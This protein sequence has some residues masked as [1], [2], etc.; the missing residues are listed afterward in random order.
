MMSLQEPVTKS[1]FSL[2]TTAF[3]MCKVDIVERTLGNVIGARWR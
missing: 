2:C 1:E 3:L